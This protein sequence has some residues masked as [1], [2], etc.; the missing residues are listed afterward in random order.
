MKRTMR[1]P[2]LLML[3]ATALASVGCGSDRN[4]G[5][6]TTVAA[7]L[8]S[9]SGLSTLDTAVREAGL[10][11]TLDGAGPFT[12]FAPTDAAFDALPAGTLDALLADKEALTEVLLGHVVS[13]R[14]PA[15]EV[16]TRSSVTTLAGFDRMIE[17][18]GSD[19][20]VGGA[21]VT[22]TDI[23]ASNGII[24]VIDAVLLPPA[25]GPGNLVEVAT[26]AGS[27]TTLL[28][29]LDA[30]E[31][32]ATLSGDGPFTVFAPTDAAFDALEASAPG[33][34]AAVLAD[35][36]LLTKILLYHVVDGEV[37]ASEVVTKSSVMTKAGLE[38]TV[39]VVGSDVF[40]GGAKVTMTDIAA[41]NGIIH[42]I[43]AVLLPPAEGPGN[44]VEVATAAGSF[45]T[46]LT[47]L[48]AAEL[49]ATLSGDGPFT[50]FA[51]T[52]A[53]FDALE[54]SAPGT[55]AAVL[56]DKELLTKILLYHVVDGE[57]PASEVVTK[58]S[59]MTKAGLELTVEVVGSDVFVGGAKVTMTDI[60][61]SNGIIHVIDAVLL[62]PAEGPGNLVEVATAA[63]SFTTL[64]T[65]LDAAELTATLSGDGPFT[66]FAPTTRP[67][68]R[69]RPRRRG[70]SRPCWP[71]RADED[72]AL[73][74]VRF[75]R[76]RW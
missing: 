4:S 8:E 23:A 30:A 16:A 27:F 63:G 61:A 18:V 36:E 67:S 68:T 11:V 60:A 48:D 70:P 51:P 34:I 74:T 19:V 35:K 31:L 20:F 15:A 56:A 12:V 54:A 41:S 7:L 13:G 45:T 9:T 6:G 37:P 53:A 33:T 64:L 47:A 24:H 26:A 17:V 55:I 75:R 3:A 65:A 22:M 44:L 50:V 76:A 43:D 21:K 28:T 2:A 52:D 39:E 71:T 14:L 40:V 38:L 57:V 62:P 66:V 25:E 1:G 42:V 5:D 49:T 10:D 46:L 69:W 59:V 32:T 72:P 73:P 29:A 58:S